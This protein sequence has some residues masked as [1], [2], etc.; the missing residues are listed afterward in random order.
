M[1]R[2]LLPFI[3]VLLILGC[4]HQVNV[5]PITIEPIHVTMDIRIRVD[6]QL[7]DFFDFEKEMQK[8][9]EK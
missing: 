9:Q 2:R 4:T 3:A 6:R 7:E 8:D 1:K 5:A